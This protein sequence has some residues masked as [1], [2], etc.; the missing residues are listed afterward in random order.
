MQGTDEMNNAAQESLDN[1]GSSA[2]SLDSL[3]DQLAAVEKPNV[4]DIPVS[5]EDLVTDPS[6]GV[7]LTGAITS[8]WDNP[9]IF[10]ILTTVLTLVLLSWVFFGKK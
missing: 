10:G 7:I 8:L 6:A 5:P 9:V 3:G 1:I 2:D 4:D